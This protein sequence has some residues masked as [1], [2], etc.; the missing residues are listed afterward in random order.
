MVTDD[1]LNAFRDA[2]YASLL[3]KQKS[4]ESELDKAQATLLEKHPRMKRQREELAKVQVE[5]DNK[6]EVMDAYRKF[7]IVDLAA[8][9]AS[10]EGVIN[11][12]LKAIETARALRG[13]LEKMKADLTTADTTIV[14]LRKDL[15][16]FDLSDEEANLE[17]MD[18][19]FGSSTPIGPNRQRIILTGLG[20][21][22]LL[23]FGL[24][25]FLHRLDDRLELAQDIEAEL[26]EPVLGQIPQV[27][28][29]TVPE[30]FLLITRLEQHNFFAESIR[31][32]R[33]AV[34]FGA[35]GR[36]KQVM[37]VTSAVPG[38]GKTTFTVN[39]AATLALAGNRVLL[40]DAD[41][42]R[43]NTH[44]YFNHERAPGLSEILTGE[45]NWRDIVKNTSMDSLDVVNSG[46]LP[47]NPGEL[48]ISPI[49]QQFLDEVRQVYDYVIIDC[50][51]LTAIDDTFSLVGL[52]DGLLFVVR[53]GQTS[54]RFAKT[55]LAAIRQR[56]SHVFGIV[57]NGITADNPYYYYNSY[58]HAY[59]NKSKSDA[60]KTSTASPG[61]RMAAP[62][63]PQ[64]RIASIQAEAKAR[65]GQKGS[66]GVV[67]DEQAKTELF[68]ARRAAQKEARLGSESPVTQPEGTT[69]PPSDDDSRQV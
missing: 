19:T 64:P 53:A 68:R 23:G 6:I 31:G 5:I 34:M 15:N 48:L 39:F 37:I 69:V 54:M 47:S 30:G 50:P 16:A 18:G 1:S 67:I 22:L 27:D 17:K 56:G 51:P 60:A 59:Y 7:K 61:V 13:E 43:G 46:Q 10:L 33:S 28:L 20:Y 66:D 38:D 36:K 3:A 14:N 63:K 44:H 55:A 40:V 9:I 26:E 65:A 41:L 62:R 4:L 11:D 42:R 25:Y 45:L 21:G 57:L 29:K 35:A 52:A 12:K 2:S 8:D 24:V 58:Y 32:I 49:T